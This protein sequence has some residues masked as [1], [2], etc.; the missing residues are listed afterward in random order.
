MK[1]ARFLCPVPEHHGT[2][3]L[4][5]AVA[6]PAGPRAEP[7]DGAVVVH[8]T[9]TDALFTAVRVCHPTRHV[10]LDDDTLVIWPPTRPGT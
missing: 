1:P 2:C 9:L 8:G 10:T 3:A 7:V 6:G 4:E 5:A